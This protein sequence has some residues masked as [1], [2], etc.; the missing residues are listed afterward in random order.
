MREPVYRLYAGVCVSVCHMQVD[1]NMNVMWRGAS[2][3]NDKINTS[4]HA[5]HACNSF[6]GLIKDS[7]SEDD[8][9]AL[10]MSHIQAKHG[11]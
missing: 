7:L 4:Q 9:S 10:S 5:L 3:T 2:I 6:W 1:A 8:V 11:L